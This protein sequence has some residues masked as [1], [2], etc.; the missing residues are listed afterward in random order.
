MSCF[1]E[2]LKTDIKLN[3]VIKKLVIKRKENPEVTRLVLL[4]SNTSIVKRTVRVITHC[5]FAK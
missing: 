4:F 2:N 5:S 1:F 3:V